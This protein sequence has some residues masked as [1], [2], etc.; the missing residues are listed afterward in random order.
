LVIVLENITFGKQKIKCVEVQKFINEE[1]FILQYDEICPDLMIGCK[2]KRFSDNV[3]SNQ[4]AIL[5]YFK[6]VPECTSSAYLESLSRL[7]L[8]NP[9]LLLE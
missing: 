2:M 9:Q 5:I 4:Y 3:K 6:F 1:V 7:G 8:P